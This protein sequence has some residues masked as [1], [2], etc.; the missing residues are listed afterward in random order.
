MRS[1]EIPSRA[2][3][4]LNFEANSKTENLSCLFLLQTDLLERP[5]VPNAKTESYSLLLNFCPWK[6]SPRHT[7]PICS[8]SQDR[9]PAEIP[10][11][12][13]FVGGDPFP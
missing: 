8:S 12:P 4:T 6:T 3:K 13:V 7:V 1:T 5:K 10:R 2:L 9:T 11:F